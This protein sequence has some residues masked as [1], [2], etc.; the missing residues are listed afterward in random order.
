MKKIILLFWIA[1]LAGCGDSFLDTESYTK[2]DDS[3]FPLTPKDAEQSL[4]GIY[5]AMTA[6]DKYQTPFVTGEIMS[7]DRLGGGGTDNAHIQAVCRFLKVSE[8]MFSGAW[9]RYY[10]GVYRCNSLLQSLAVIKWENDDQRAKIES[11]T[12]F[13]RAFFYFDLARM[14][15]TVPLVIDPVPQNI[16]RTPA[17]EIFAQI[18][19]D[20]KFAVEHLGAVRFQ[21]IPKSE[22]GH[23]SKWAAEGLMSRVFLF[24]TGYYKKESLPLTGGGVVSKNE[25]IAWVDDC[26]ANSGHDLIPDFRNLWP[27]ALASDV[28]KY[29]VD[30][31][32]E[33]I[34]EEGDNLETVFAEKHSALGN[35]D[36][37]DNGGG[38]ANML[39]CYF[40]LRVQDYE[41]TIPF[42]EG[43]GFGPV[44]P[45]LWND[46]PDEDIR[47][48]A[49]ILDVND[50]SEI[51]GFK[52]GGDRQMEETGYWQKKYMP[53]YI[54]D[55]NGRPMNYTVLWYGAVNDFMLDNAQDLVVIRFAD[56]LLMGA[57]L[58]STH[59]QSYLDRVRTR[60]G[61][62]SAPVTLDAIKRERHY[63]LAF[64]GL[65][66]YDLLRWHDEHLITENQ[67]NIPVK[68]NNVAGA[69]SVNFRAETGGFLPI[70]QRQITLS[71]NVL[72]QSPGWPTGAEYMFSNSY[73]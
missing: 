67:Q 73:Q 4:A 31:Q 50:R 1:A 2:K 15:G 27:Y 40:G 3:N 58:G 19:F 21:D 18:G 35:W 22:L 6:I 10:R 34:G 41:K 69:I 61:L 39:N 28:Y 43:W 25:V 20:L 9:Y 59:A 46:W 12:R 60:V 36:D 54:R 23:V 55:E 63:E 29:A 64:E 65:R 42:G 37:Y 62:P 52:W 45:K 26:V 51:A 71:N 57:E 66:Y 33:W 13:M 24:Y 17:D 47:K 5:S 30:N 14:F 70:P 38:Y 16:P 7:D 56:I 53:I 68:N 11:E 44:N 8:D 49:S 72:V 32:L 48:K